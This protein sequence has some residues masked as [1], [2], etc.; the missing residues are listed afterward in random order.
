MRV[1]FANWSDEKWK[2]FYERKYPALSVLERKY[3]A[4]RICQR[5]GIT[6]PLWKG[7]KSKRET[8][9]LLF[10]YDRFVHSPLAC[11]LYQNF[12]DQILFPRVRRPKVDRKR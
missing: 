5:R 7:K 12:R 1:G 4:A 2:R 10:L 8:Q 6:V 3:L 9:K 11:R